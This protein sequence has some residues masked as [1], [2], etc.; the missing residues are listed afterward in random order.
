MT[1]VPELL[2]VDDFDRGAALD[3]GRIG[4]R[5]CGW[6]AAVYACCNA[7]RNSLTWTAA[8]VVPAVSDASVHANA[9]R[10]NL[11]R[12]T[13]MRVRSSMRCT[14]RIGLEPAISGSSLNR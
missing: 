3:E 8:T 10:P 9:A 5:R 2:E 13:S 12:C 6:P 7:V 14:T 1:R 11:A 4:E